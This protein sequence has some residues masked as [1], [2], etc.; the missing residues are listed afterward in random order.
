MNSNCCYWRLLIARTAREAQGTTQR[1]RPAD[2]AE[3]TS[4]K[5]QCEEGL[6]QQAQSAQVEAM[7][8]RLAWREVFSITYCYQGGGSGC[9]DCEPFQGGIIRRQ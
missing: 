4:S 5:C 3:R 6:N 8:W 1:L 2:G 9:V 7:R